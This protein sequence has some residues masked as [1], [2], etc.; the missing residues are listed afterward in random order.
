MKKMLTILF[1]GLC[2]GGIVY[3]IVKIPVVSQ[4]ISC[5][6]QNTQTFDAAEYGSRA[7]GYSDLKRCGMEQESVYQLGQCIAATGNND[8]L[9]GN[10]YQMIIQVLPIVRPGNKSIEQMQLDHNTNCAD[11]PSTLFDMKGN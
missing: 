11:Y 10:V 5:Y 4:I 1:Y 6:D 7:Q 2:L 8:R 9:P 3:V